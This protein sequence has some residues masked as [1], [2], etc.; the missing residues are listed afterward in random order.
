MYLVSIGTAERGRQFCTQTLFPPELLLCDPE[1]VTYTALGLKKG[2]RQTFLSYETPLAMWQR[3][4]G[5]DMSDLKAVL[6]RWTKQ[7]LWVPPKADQA[8]QQGGAVVFDGKR[9]VFAHYD[10]ATSA[11]VDFKLLIREATR[12]L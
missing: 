12:G 4:K 1:N 11:H 2:I 10:A 9:L 6:S 7:E 5:G 8:Y 3:I